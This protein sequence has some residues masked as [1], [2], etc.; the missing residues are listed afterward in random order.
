MRLLICY[1]LIS[2]FGHCDSIA[3][4]PPKSYPAANNACLELP[5][6]LRQLQG[7]AGRHSAAQKY[8]LYLSSLVKSMAKSSSD[9]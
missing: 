2:F 3:D 8:F 7:T 4:E 5:F 1:I 6:G 9:Q